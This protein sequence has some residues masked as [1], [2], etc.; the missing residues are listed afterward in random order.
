MSGLI[1]LQQFTQTASVAATSG[2]AI[3]FTGIPSWVNL[4]FASFYQISLN[5]SSAIR[6]QLGTSGGIVT[7]GYVASSLNATNGVSPSVANHTSGFFLNTASAANL[8]SGNMVLT[9]NT[10]NTWV[11]SLNAALSNNPNTL[12]CAGGIAL[13]D[14]LTQIRFGSSNG[15]AAFDGSGTIS[16][17]F[18]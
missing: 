7:T 18:R 8:H 9:R 1:R 2:A 3:D 15:T 13:A 16:I 11:M 6:I 12:L 17:G 10:G 4:I 5:G 14:E